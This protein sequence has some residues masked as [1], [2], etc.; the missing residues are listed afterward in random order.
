MPS[1]EAV[2]PPA[3]GGEQSTTVVIV[4]KKSF[5][6]QDFRLPPAP[7]YDKIP[8][9]LPLEKVYF[10]AS[11]VFNSL[12]AFCGDML[13]EF[14]TARQPPLERAR[15]LLDETAAVLSLNYNALL[16]VM[17]GDLDGEYRPAHCARTSI[18][19]LLAGL[20]LG[21]S[22]ERARN[23]G[24]S[25][26]FCD[27]GMAL[28]PDIPDCPHPLTLPAEGGVDALRQH[29]VL[30]LGCMAHNV[31]CREILRGIAEH[32]ER[33]DGTGYPVGLSGERISLAGK[34]L[35]VADSY[36]ALICV[37]PHSAPLPPHLA[38]ARLRDLGGAAFDRDVLEHVI[39]CLGAYPVGSVVETADGR[40]AVVVGNSPDTPLQPVVR[41][42][43]SFSENAAGP[44][45]FCAQKAGRITT[46]FSLSGQ[47]GGPGEF[48][49]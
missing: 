6:A 46:V 12:R 15:A 3:L 10:A 13:R 9:R 24:L 34:I 1:R 43:R 22:P 8:P 36:D 30:G 32:H 27:V 11:R 2:R 23:L 17:M 25:A 28:L 44:G 31:R 14:N 7:G 29:P 16:G 47:W 45:A 40:R 39:R 49:D 48:N 20:Q 38:L 41:P 4:L 26:M 19:A 37:H 18:L 33:V 5:P 21:L 42:L 35:A